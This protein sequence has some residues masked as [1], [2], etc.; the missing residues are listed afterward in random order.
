LKAYKEDNIFGADSNWLLRNVMK[1]RD[2]PKEVNKVIDEL[3]DF[4]DSG[5][6]VSAKLKRTELENMPIGNYDQI[7][8]KADV[9]IRR[10]EILSE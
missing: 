8:A 3:F 4:I 5:D 10:K 9:L 2:R 1:D 7:L 6:L